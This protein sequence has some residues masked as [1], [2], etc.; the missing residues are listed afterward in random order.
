ME[1][2]T[3]VVSTPSAVAGS[4]YF[5]VWVLLLGL[6]GCR[7][8]PPVAPPAD[9]GNIPAAG[10]FS[11]PPGAT[12]L[13]VDTRR[14]LLQVFVF[15]GGAMAKL[16]H[17]HLIASRGLTGSVYLTRDSLATRFD[18]SF[19]VN[20]LT[21]D[22]PALRAAAGPDFA[23]NV[24]QSAREGTRGN[25]L[26]PALLDGSNYPAIQLRATDIRAAGDGFDAGVEVILKGARHQVR[27]PLQ[28]QRS[29]GAVVASGEFALLQS[30]LGL[31]PFTAAMGTLVVLDQMRVRFEI[32]AGPG[33]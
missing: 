19:P 1:T 3:H 17:N 8:T 2:R 12:E 29:E 32:R 5:V 27:V 11:I 10:V 13:K 25:L 22:D 4:R 31:Q 28:V 16:G 15:R 23:A 33:A 26:S 18:I 14:S 9:S 20:E 6:V 24:P 30:Q 7:T 21:V